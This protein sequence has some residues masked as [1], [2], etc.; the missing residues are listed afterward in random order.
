MKKIITI[1][2]LVFAF[3]VTVQAQKKEGK[4]P[5]EKMLA[6]LT[7]DLD[8]TDAQQKDIK[9]LLEAQMAERKIMADKRKAL[10]ESGEKPTKEE[11]TK[12]QEARAA[13][14]AAMDAK[15]ESILDATQLEKYKLQKEAMKKE[16]PKKNK[17]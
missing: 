13:S 2:V 14:E 7:T 6:K 11:R 10:Q 4:A 5:V 3:T 17:Q 9:P 12:M 16:G 15:M 8:L 1:L